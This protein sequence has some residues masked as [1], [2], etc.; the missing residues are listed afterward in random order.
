ME[1]TSSQLKRH[2]GTVMVGNT[3]DS[4]RT[5]CMMEECLPLSGVNLSNHGISILSFTLPTSS[6]WRICA[7]QADILSSKS[8]R[9]SCGES[10][11]GNYTKDSDGIFHIT[12]RQIK[13]PLLII[14]QKGALMP[15]MMMCELPP[16]LG[17]KGE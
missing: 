5:S 3:S 8:F 10:S 4:K 1:R 17:N 16:S 11:V 14:K 2:C 6:L 7:V 15:L 12:Y 9:I 13:N